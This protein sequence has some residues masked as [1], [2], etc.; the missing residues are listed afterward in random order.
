MND[1][2]KKVNSSEEGNDI[3][4]KEAE[5]AEEEVKEDTETEVENNKK[6]NEDNTED[7]LAK[8]KE[9][10]S[11]QKDNYL[12]LCAE[13]DNFRKRSAKEKTEIFGD[14]TIKAVTDFLS[15][16]DNFERAVNCECS[17]E[18]Y[19]K[20][21]E[22]IFDQYLEI[23]KKLKITEIEAEGKTFDPNFHNAVNQIVD[24][25]LPDNTVAHVFQKGYKYGDKVIR[26]A[27]VV[28]ANP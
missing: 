4:T 3:E 17:D 13:F 26:H 12:R 1:S 21:M 23:L 18:N 19:K 6:D 7:E 11:E 10:L 20:G 25:N 24:E 14:A 16:I 22:M 5:V 28:V 15:V 2:E 27:M 8:I 9:E